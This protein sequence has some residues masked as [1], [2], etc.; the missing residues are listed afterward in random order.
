MNHITFCLSL[1]CTANFMVKGPN[2]SD[3]EVFKFN[4]GDMLVFDPSTEANILHEVK[5]IDEVSN[6]FSKKKSKSYS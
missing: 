6:F 1:G 5:S 2:M 4:S 3:K